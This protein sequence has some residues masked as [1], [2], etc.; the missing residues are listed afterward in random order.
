MS[1]TKEIETFRKSVSN[2]NPQ[3]AMDHFI[4]LTQPVK[5]NGDTPFGEPDV[6][7]FRVRADRIDWLADCSSS[8]HG[9]FT[10]VSVGGKKLYRCKIGC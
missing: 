8:E 2:W 10:I 1:E 4:V 6:A 3:G 7:H 9:E 5:P